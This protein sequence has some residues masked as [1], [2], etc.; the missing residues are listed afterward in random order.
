MRIGCV[1]NSVG[2]DTPVGDVVKAVKGTSRDRNLT[3]GGAEVLLE[4][5]GTIAGSTSI[6]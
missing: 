5:Y 4:K 6:I 3:Q 1:A 2:V